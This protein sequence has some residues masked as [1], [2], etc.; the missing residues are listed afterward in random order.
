[1]SSKAPRSIRAAR[2]RVLV[3]ALV[4]LLV[5]LF[6]AL[7]LPVPF[8]KLAPGPTFNVIGTVAGKDVISISGARTDPTSGQLDMTTVYEKGGPQGGLSFVEAVAS[9]FS[10]ADAVLPQE[11]L[12]PDNVTSAQ[13]NQ[14]NASMFSLAESDATAAAM[15]Y[16]HR[17]LTVKVVITSTVAKSPADGKLVA[18]EQIVSINGTQIHGAQQVADIVRQSPVGTSFDF[19]VIAPNETTVTHHLVISEATPQQASKPYIGIGVG[20]MY[21][22]GFPVHFSLSGIGGPSA[23][24]M[25]ALGLVDKLT[26][27]DLAQGHHIAGTGTISPD[28]TIGPIGGI[29]QKLI[30]ASRAGAALFLMPID[31]CAEVAG[32]I[33]AGLTVVP[34]HTLSQSVSAVQHWTAG[35]AVPQCSSKS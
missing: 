27:G 35:A 8:I 9:W 13:V 30:G 31:H 11:T 15:N 22:A 19:A 17:P 2:A 25:F 16:L 12:Y 6:V 4:S 7:V 20:D 14:Y 21:D 1:M 5:L 32:H 18:G 3:V 23:G 34:V 29:R 24:A 10:S 33:P 28:G 26:P